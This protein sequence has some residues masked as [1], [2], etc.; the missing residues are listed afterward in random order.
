[1]FTRKRKHGGK[2]LGQGAYGC[3]FKPALPCKGRNKRTPN[4]IT[5]LVGPNAFYHEY[6]PK[7]LLE[8]ID[9]EQKYFLYPLS[10]C[11][12]DEWKLEPENNIGKCTLPFVNVSHERRKLG[13]SKSIEF[14]YGGKDLD[15]V[16]LH[17]SEYI[18]AF[19]GFSKIFEAVTVLHRKNIVH[20]DIK[21]GNLVTKKLPDNTWDFHMI[22]F[23]SHTTI[24]LESW[25][26]AAQRVLNCMYTILFETDPVTPDAVYEL[27]VSFDFLQR[28]LSWSN[29]QHIVRQKLLPAR[30]F[31]KRKTGEDL[32]FQN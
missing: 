9:P 10:V 24:S 31:T 22:D 18:G 19:N 28:L 25:I 27:G 20:L 11:D 6:Q 32:T 17:P 1:M 16:H 30:V 14:G 3:A 26:I 8:G 29:A 15:E 5:K 2:Y 4:A 7:T 12:I 21:P 23:V 13:N